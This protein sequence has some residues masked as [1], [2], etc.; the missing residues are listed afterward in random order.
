MELYLED[1]QDTH[2]YDIVKNLIAGCEDNKNIAGF[3]LEVRS[4]PVSHTGNLFCYCDPDDENDILHFFTSESDMA[5]YLASHIDG[6]Y[7]WKSM[8]DEELKHF[9]N[10]YEEFGPQ[11]PCFSYE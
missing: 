2:L 8:T 4:I 3:F 10:M 5:E 7:E 11:I 9:L 1:L 6:S